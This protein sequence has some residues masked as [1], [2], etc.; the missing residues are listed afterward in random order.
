MGEAF[1]SYH[2]N[3]LIREYD[4]R[5]MAKWIGFYLSEHTTAMQNEQ[6]RQTTVYFIKPTMTPE[7]ITQTIEDAL[8]HTKRISVQLN[9]VDQE[10]HAYEDIYGS[11][12]GYDTQSLFVFQ[13]NGEVT[14]IQTEL[15]NHVTIIEANKWSCLS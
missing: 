6:S 13:E 11:I 8:L 14:K 9:E 4:D 15:I 10:G 3:R 2:P 12:A 5:K 7:A 1:M